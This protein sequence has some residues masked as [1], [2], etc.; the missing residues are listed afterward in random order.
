MPPENILFTKKL[1]TI[2][3]NIVSVLLEIDLLEWL[4]VYLNLML[5]KSEA[6]SQL[7]LYDCCSTYYIASLVMGV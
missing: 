2:K 6:F 4:T 7:M 3:N 5:Q 1:F